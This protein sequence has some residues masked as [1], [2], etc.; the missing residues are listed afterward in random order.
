[1]EAFERCVKMAVKLQTDW[2]K[3]LPQDGIVPQPLIM[4]YMSNTAL[5]LINS[6]SLSVVPAEIAEIIESGIKLAESGKRQDGIK[7][8][9]IDIFE[10]FR[11]VA[12]LFNKALTNETELPEIIDAL[13]KEGHISKDVWGKLLDLLLILDGLKMQDEILD[14]DLE[15]LHEI[16][17]DLKKQKI[18][19]LSDHGGNLSYFYANVTRIKALNS[20]SLLP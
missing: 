12:N 14:G 20:T 2:I 5:P 4:G 17:D 10:Y 7:K 15:L 11:D 8:I 1:M 16:S 19:H 18:S 13:R 9:N 3:N 6:I